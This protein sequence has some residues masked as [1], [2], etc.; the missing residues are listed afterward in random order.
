MG[1]KNM[2][3][4][5]LR[6]SVISA[7]LVPAL[8][9]LG[10]CA[11]SGEKME[12]N[13]GSGMMSSESYTEIGE[14]AEGRVVRLSSDANQAQ[15]IWIRDEHTTRLYPAKNIGGDNWVLTKQGLAQYQADKAAQ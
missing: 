13:M 6:K 2:S 11:S 9:A 12:D 1:F 10:G 3:V 8:F 5:T 15:G 7:L 14:A 4:V